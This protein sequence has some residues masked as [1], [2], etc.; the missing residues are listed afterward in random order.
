MLDLLLAAGAVV[1][2]VVVT[3]VLMRSERLG[4]SRIALALAVAVLAAGT[5]AVALYRSQTDDPD[6]PALPR[7]TTLPEITASSPAQQGLGIA[8]VPVEVPMGSGD[9]LPQ[10]ALWLSP[11]RPGTDAYTGDVSLLCSTP[12]K[13]DHDQNCAGADQRVWTV[14]PLAKRALLGPASGDPFDDPAACAESSGVAYRAAYLE[15]TPGRAYC[16]R[17][18][19]DPS[20]TIAL[21]VPSFPADRPLPKKLVVETAILSS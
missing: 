3:V 13:T 16:L 17:R 9:K 8:V 20:R 14:E 6:S 18:A 2:L 15:L 11:T 10:G 5:F 12:G 1:L 7:I 4:R 21:R 19:A